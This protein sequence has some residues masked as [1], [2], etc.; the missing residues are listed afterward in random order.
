MALASS[1]LDS[2]PRT[3]R[4]CSGSTSH[5]PTWKLEPKE[6]LSIRGILLDPRAFSQGPSHGRAVIFSRATFPRLPMWSRHRF[7]WRKDG[8]S[9]DPPEMAHVQCLNGELPSEGGCRDERVRLRQLKLRC[10]QSRVCARHSRVD[11]HLPKPPQECEDRATLRGLQAGL[12]EKLFL[13]YGRVVGATTGVFQVG[14]MSSP[15]EI[16]DE[17][18]RVD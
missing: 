15:V 9:C 7:F 4:L 11:P 1:L 12:R 18:V 6:S 17:D 2:L 16:R 3:T 5:S 8:K 10:A 13:G 14:S